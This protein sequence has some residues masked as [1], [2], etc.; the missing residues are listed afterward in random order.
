MKKALLLILALIVVVSS[1]LVSCSADKTNENDPTTT[2]ANLQ[3]G[4]TEIGFETD[5]NGEE[6]PVEYVTD[7]DGKTI[8]VKLDKNG[9][10][11]TN[12]SG[13]YVT[14]KTDFEKDTTNKNN[15]GSTSNNEKLTTTTKPAPT[16]TTKK[17]VPLTSSKETTKFSGSENVP[18]TSAKGKE[19]SFSA[20]DQSTITAMLEVPYLYLSSYE[21]SDGVPINIACHVAVW[22]AEREGGVSGTYPSGPVVLN[23]FKYFGQTVV[24]FKTQCNEFAAEGNAPIKYT[25]NDTFTISE[26]TA[27]KQT[28]K[29]TKIEDLGDNNF[30]KVT[31][32]VSGCSK[33]NVVAIVQ[34]NKLD[35]T[36]GF[37]IKALKWS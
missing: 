37:S 24:N 30:Y 4:D 15:N 34:K 35:T 28:V 32:K 23:L 7:K 3:N 25:N 27:K 16:A 17:D 19:V 2:E 10:K 14:L 18:K 36:L 29:I 21:N 33:K 1:I 6:V 11:V 8:A 12:K 26:Y 20:E 22:M 13:E 5:E 9:E 31:G